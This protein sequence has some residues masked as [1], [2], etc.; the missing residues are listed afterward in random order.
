MS[1]RVL[2]TLAGTK[3]GLLS[4]I[5]LLVELR[6]RGCFIRTAC[7]SIM[8]HAEGLLSCTGAN[9][10][11]K[12]FVWRKTIIK[13]EAAIQ[14]KGWSPDI[15][16]NPCNYIC[17]DSKFPHIFVIIISLSLQAVVIWP[18]NSTSVIKNKY[19]NFKKYSSTPK[20]TLCELKSYFVFQK[21]IATELGVSEINPKNEL[22]QG[23][24]KRSWISKREP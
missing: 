15:I 7:V 18:F 17:L 13:T 14:I 11:F 8:W 23:F 22:K 1:M 19:N 10:S 4:Q 9:C 2:S 5:L 6:T 3:I 21:S 20:P 16:S 12:M 24:C